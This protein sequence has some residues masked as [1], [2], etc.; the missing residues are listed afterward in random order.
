MKSVYKKL[1]SFQE[2]IRLAKATIRPV[3]G[4]EMVP[5]TESS[6]RILASAV[7]APRDNP[8]FNR[9]TMDGYA[10]RA[11]EVAEASEVAPALLNIVGE[12][13]IGQPR[14]KMDGGNC[15]FR[16][17]TGAII[18]EGSDAV[19]RV[20]DTEESGVG[21]VKIL[22]AA[23]KGSN[24]AEAGSDISIHEVLSLPGKEID[25]NDIAVMASLGI[26]EVEVYRKLL[27][28]V[29]S[30]GNE[31]ISHEQPYREG[32]ISDANG[33]ALCNELN[34]FRFIQ[35]TYAGIAR[36]NYEEIKN[37]IK[38]NLD[39]NDIVI[40]SGGSSAG[41]SDLVYRIIGE[42]EKIGFPSAS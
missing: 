12:S 24:I 14:M 11:R 32:S 37:R 36:D 9:S 39:E 31:L 10:V 41:E 22:E 40:L 15:C 4:T 17:S 30:T 18:P 29:I 16:I 28:T 1:V 38:E 13:F 27:I 5:I 33:I 26:H 7:F 23:A 34:Q 35:A 25:T 20:E 19:V 6:G 21:K 42:M 3:E 2:A 8:P